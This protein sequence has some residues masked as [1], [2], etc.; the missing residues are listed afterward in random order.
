MNTSNSSE[1]GHNAELQARV[2]Q[3]PPKFL[4]SLLQ[5]QPGA[6]VPLLRD[7]LSGSHLPVLGWSDSADSLVLRITD[8]QSTGDDRN[9]DRSGHRVRGHRNRTLRSWRLAGY[10]LTLLV[11]FALLTGC[12]GSG[13]VT[14]QPTPASPS[15]TP[16]GPATIPAPVPS[17]TYP[18]REQDR[19]LFELTW[20]S[21]TDSEKIATCEIVGGMTEDWLVNFFREQNPTSTTDYRAQVILMKEKC[22]NESL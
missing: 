11:L 12:G 19:L 14:P 7:S 1:A 17:R 2:V 16:S 8:A 4:G 9:S 20:T 21:L 10:A 15:Q 5:G 6:V 18:V 22:L 3:G 13:G